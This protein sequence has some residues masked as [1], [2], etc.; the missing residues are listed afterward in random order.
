MAKES[1]GVGF[2]ATCFCVLARCSLI[3]SQTLKSSSSKTDKVTKGVTNGLC[4]LPIVFMSVPT[5]VLR[6]DVNSSSKLTKHGSSAVA[7]DSLQVLE[8]AVVLIQVLGMM[9]RELVALTC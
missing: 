9:T 3:K 8:G 1:V 7:R 2:V 5:R 6:N 4:V